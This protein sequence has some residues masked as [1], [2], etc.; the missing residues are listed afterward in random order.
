MWGM[1][2]PADERTSRHYGEV[3]A[4]NTLDHSTVQGPVVQARDIQQLTIADAS[5]L[6]ERYQA[7]AN[8]CSVWEKLEPH[9]WLVAASLWAV[10]SRDE[11]EDML[12]RSDSLFHDLERHHRRISLLDGENALSRLVLEAAKRAV[13]AVGPYMYALGRGDD[14]AISAAEARNY[15][16][17]MAINEAK[18]AFDCFMRE[19]SARLSGRGGNV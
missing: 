16:S 3:D 15:E 5:L 17:L 8:F 2:P 19:A 1:E 6:S 7:Y 11:Y 13:R 10:S 12:Y 4:A 9:I 18:D 14:E